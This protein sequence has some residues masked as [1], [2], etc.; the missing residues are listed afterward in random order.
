MSPR[1]G[2]RQKPAHPRKS[3]PAGPRR[4]CKR[5]WGGGPVPDCNARR[6][7][8]V[9]YAQTQG[10][11]MEGGR[12]GGAEL[13]PRRPLQ[14]LSEWRRTAT[15]TAA[16]EAATR[17]KWDERA[18]S[19]RDGFCPGGRRGRQSRTWRAI[20]SAFALAIGPAPHRGPPCQ[21]GHP[22][23]V[24]VFSS[25]ARPPL[26]GKQRPALRKM[27]AARLAPR[28]SRQNRLATAWRS[29]G[30]CVRVSP[31]RAGG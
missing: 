18:W 17:E 26:V 15:V 27:C 6:A 25:L 1:L 11:R 29:Y 20:S 5:Q 4:H 16:A 31:G 13:R 7:D 9:P 30:C 23:F 19:G 21:A 8:Y 24:A 2:L 3:A 28:S 10:G 22:E 14:S 12:G